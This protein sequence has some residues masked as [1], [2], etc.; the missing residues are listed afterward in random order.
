MWASE[1]QPFD[2][3]EQALHQAYAQ[4]AAPD[5]RPD[6]HMVHEYPLDGRP[7]MMTHVFADAS[8]H[9]IVACKGAAE[10]IVERCHLPAT[11]QAAVL[12]VLTQMAATGL[13]VLGVAHCPAPPPT[14][15][16]D[17]ED[18]NWEFVGL[19]AFPTRPSPPAPLCSG[20]F[21]RPACK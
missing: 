2:P 1:P 8:G 13:R 6:Y 17:Q 16:D 10:G 14:F 11:A 19:V 5:E 3:M 12:E 21:T 18:F 9:R 15:P 4:T 7:P 20:S